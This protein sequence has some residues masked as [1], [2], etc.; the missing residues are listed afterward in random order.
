MVS[1]K[2][3]GGVRVRTMHISSFTMRSADNAYFMIRI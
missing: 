2:G 1:S 3:G